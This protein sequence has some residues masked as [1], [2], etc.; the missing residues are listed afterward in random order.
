LHCQATV[1]VIAKLR[2]GTSVSFAAPDPLL[3]FTLARAAV[4]LVTINLGAE[5]L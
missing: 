4:R 2:V 1:R 5:P 3:L